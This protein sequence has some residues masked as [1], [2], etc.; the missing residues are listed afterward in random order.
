[1]DAHPGLMRLE[2][3]PR[4]E[5]NVVGRH[6]GN[7]PLLRQIEYGLRVHRLPA[8]PRALYLEIEAIAAEHL[9]TREASCR[10]VLLA[11]RQ[12]L[13]DISLRAPR[14]HDQ[15]LEHV[16]LQPSAL[17]HRGAA[18]LAL[19]EGTRYQLGQMPVADQILT[20]KQDPRGR[21][22]PVA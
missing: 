20:Q 13:P 14:E 8:A 10:L 15:P 3:G 6:G 17:Q 22:L 11:A 5:A 12:G 19:E 16:P 7:A 18:P 4:Q 2:L 1:M 21:A 9:P